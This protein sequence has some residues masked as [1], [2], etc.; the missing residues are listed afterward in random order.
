MLGEINVKDKVE[1]IVLDEKILPFPFEGYTVTDFIG[2]FNT[3]GKITEGPVSGLSTYARTRHGLLMYNKFL[4][5]LYKKYE[6]ELDG[7]DARLFQWL[8]YYISGLSTILGME[9]KK[10]PYQQVDLKTILGVLSLPEK[11]YELY[12]DY[13]SSIAVVYIN[14]ATEFE[15]LKSVSDVAEELLAEYKHKQRIDLG[16]LPSADET[17]GPSLSLSIKNNQ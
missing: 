13:L 7:E 2:V 14:H 6:K 15:G 5:M 11:D 10:L 12:K 16:T 3:F 1:N 9:V 4:M 17:N 8:C